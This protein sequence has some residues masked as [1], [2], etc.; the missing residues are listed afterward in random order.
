[1]SRLIYTIIV[2][3][4]ALF[5]AS[6]VLPGFSFEGGWVAPLIFA[7]ILIVLNVVIK[8]IMKLLSFP[9]IFITGGLF[10]V[11]INAVTLYLAEYILRVMDVS[12]VSVQ[13]ET[14]LTY[15]WA[16]IIFGVANWLIHWFL[17]D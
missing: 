11:L 14:P 15:L 9:L 13:F 16:A 7:I 5:G 1:M 12:G 6:Y 4:L 2:N 17:K 10:L 8:P 3:A